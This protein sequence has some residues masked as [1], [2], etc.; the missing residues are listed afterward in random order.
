MNTVCVCVC[1]CECSSCLSLF[2]PRNHRAEAE[3]SHVKPAYS[4]AARA[5]Q[6]HTK[7]KDNTVQAWANVI[8]SYF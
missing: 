8:S 3:A 5:Q 7:G 1:V 6:E 4:A 2:S